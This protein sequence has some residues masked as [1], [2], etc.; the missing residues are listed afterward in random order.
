[1]QPP[2]QTFSVLSFLGVVVQFGG[3]LMLIG[4]FLMLRRF[5]LRRSYFVAWTTAWAA[6]AVA[7]LA[8]VIRYV[9]MPGLAG[10]QFDDA[11][12]AI[13]ALYFVYQSGKALAFVFFVRGTLM[14]VA[15]ATESVVATRRLWMAAAL[16]AV[17]STF[18]SRH[19]LNEMVIWQSAVAVPALGYCASA[20]LWLPRPR[21]TAGSMTTGACFALLAALWLAYAG[22]FA[23]VIHKVHTPLAQRAGEL[24]AFNS[25]FDLALDILLGYAMILVLMED[26]KR[27]VDDAQ[28][29]LRLTH[30]QLRR[31]ALYDSL[32]DSLNRRAF[33]EGVGLDMVR[34]TFGTV[35]LA[36]LDNLKL[37]NDRFG[38]AAGDQLIR[39]CADVLR[40]TLRSY[41]K[42]YRWGGDEFLLIVP[43]AHASD[44]LRRLQ[45]A[46]DE[47]APVEAAAVTR[48]EDE[49]TD[50]PAAREVIRLQVSLGAADYASSE[51]LSVA[52]ERA[53]RA[54]YL[55]KS[56]RK[57]DPRSS[58]AFGAPAGR[59][60]SV[61]SP[62]SVPAVR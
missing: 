38:H 57:S 7:I 44:V 43:S 15:G 19:G 12:L 62:T 28:A 59:G 34:A 14:Y 5:V 25:Y 33:A 36:D 61:Q 2:A 51:E 54:M 48:D 24:V 53:D 35:V 21:R 1:M 16:F 22:A 52:I 30:D 23:V 41:D 31:A 11:D 27:E 17:L 6:L 32:T 18:V 47:A 49:D 56:R 45:L 29:E 42:L 46:I 4:L 3:A 55:E 8:L 58:A 37:V 50:G 26:A 39:R 10:R 13:R 9:L 40:A 60:R 20:L